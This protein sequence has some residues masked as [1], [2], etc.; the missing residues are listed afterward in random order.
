M[1]HF[2]FRTLGLERLEMEVHMENDAAAGATR[3][4]VSCWKASSAMLSSP[5]GAFAMWAFSA[6]LSEE[7]EARA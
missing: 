2:A 6:C 5:T 4:P 7:Y 3:K 1:Q